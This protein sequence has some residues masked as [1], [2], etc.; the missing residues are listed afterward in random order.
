[1]EYERF[2]HVVK[3]LGGFLLLLRVPALD[4]ETLALEDA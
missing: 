2:V 3:Q 1:V 4:D